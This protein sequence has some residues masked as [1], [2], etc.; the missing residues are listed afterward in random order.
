MGVSLIFVLLT[1]LLVLNGWLYVQQPAMI[2]F[3]YA[4]LES[5]PRDWGFAYE[6]VTLEASDGV[7]LHGWYIPCTGSRRALLFLHGNA[8]NISHRGDSVAIFHRLGFNVFIFDYRGYGRSAGHPTEAGLYRDAEASWQYLIKSKGFAAED[9]V[10]FGR[11]LGGA[12]AANLAVKVQPAALILE[13]TFSSARDLAH[14]A[15]PVLSRL[16]MIRFNFDTQARVRELAAP[17][18]VIHSPQDEIIPYELGRK[19]FDASLSPKSFLAMQGDHNTGFLRSQ[20]AYEQGISEFLSKG[21]FKDG[22]PD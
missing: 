2:F 12:V 14:S 13:S 7:R 3:P 6:E 16:V 9:V 5:T 20:P 4:A 21:V 10:I 15:F 17:V 22:V 1:L 19:V 11:S 8:G 18:L